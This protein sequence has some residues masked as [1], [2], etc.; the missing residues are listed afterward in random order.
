[1][2]I[3][4]KLLKSLET[5]PVLM[6]DLVSVELA[7]AY[8]EKLDGLLVR[9]GEEEALD[10]AAHH[11][12]VITEIDIVGRRLEAMLDRLGLSPAARPAVPSGG[13][14]AVPD[15]TAAALDGLVRDA[16]RRNAGGT[17]SEED[18]AGWFGVDPDVT[19]LIGEENRALAWPGLSALP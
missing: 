3:H 14:P 1:M 7:L 9:L 5:T 11:K 16:E 12:R 10:S 18:D 19:A 2:T 15:P 8:A 4:S 13:G 6:R 17:V